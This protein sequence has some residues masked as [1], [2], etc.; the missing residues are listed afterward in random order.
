MKKISK[1]FLV[2]LF[3]TVITSCKKDCSLRSDCG[4]VFY[5]Y[6]NEKQFFNVSNAKII[7]G[8]SDSLTFAEMK[9]ITD[10]YS[11]IEPLKEDQA[12]LSK[13]F[14]SADLNKKMSCDKIHKC[15]CDLKDNP[16]IMYANLCFFREG[17]NDL[18]G[19]SDEFIVCLKDSLQLPELQAMAQLTSTSILRQNEFNSNIYILSA[20]KY[21]MGNALEMANYFYE[22]NKFVWSEPNLIS[23]TA[24]NE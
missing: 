17:S 5:Y 11:F 10:Q 22:S 24:F 13:K 8:F 2:I 4:Q 15:M 20:T 14:A 19:Y 21:S 7:I 12:C 1:L 9:L 6:Q 18:S 23:Y 3:I 16:D